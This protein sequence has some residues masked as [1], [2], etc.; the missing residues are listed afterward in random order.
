MFYVRKKFFKKM[1]K[2]IFTT[3]ECMET[4]LSMT[5]IPLSEYPLYMCKYPVC[6]FQVGLIIQYFTLILRFTLRFINYITTLIYSV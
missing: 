5:Q 1:Y 2:V 3:C 4:I 6:P